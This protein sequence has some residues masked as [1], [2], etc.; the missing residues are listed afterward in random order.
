VVPGSVFN[1]F[2]TVAW[3]SP[4]PLAD[5]LAT[6]LATGQDTTIRRD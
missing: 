3:S 1:G 5:S 4:M 6:A 2:R